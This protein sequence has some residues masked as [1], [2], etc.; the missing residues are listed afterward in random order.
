VFIVRLVRSLADALFFVDDSFSQPSFP[1][2]RPN[3]LPHHAKSA[4]FLSLLFREARIVASTRCEIPP[5]RHWTHLALGRRSPY[6]HQV[7]ST[8]TALLIAF[9]G[10][11]SPP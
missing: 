1:S 4:I 11:Q 7:F 5:L 6:S 2:G 8:C 10:P 9:P 3:L